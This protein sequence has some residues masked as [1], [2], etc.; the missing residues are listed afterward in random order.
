MLVVVVAPPPP[1]APPDVTKPSLA[2]LTIQLSVVGGASGAEEKDMRVVRGRR[3]RESG[4]A[5]ARRSH[6]YRTTAASR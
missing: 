1:L 6:L 2:Q 4:M 3:P 5:R